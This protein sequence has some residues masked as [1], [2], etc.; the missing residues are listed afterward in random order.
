MQRPYSFL[1]YTFSLLLISALLGCIPEVGWSPDGRYLYFPAKGEIARWDSQTEQTQ[2]FP[3]PDATTVYQANVLFD[4]SILIQTNDKL[5]KCSSDGTSW[6]TLAEDADLFYQISNQ[7]HL[8]YTKTDQEKK[9]SQLFRDDETMPLWSAKEEFAY[10][11]VDASERQLLLATSHGLLL[12]DLQTRKAKMLS[13]PEKFCIPAAW[14]DE[15]TI[16]YLAMQKEDDAFG[17][18]MAYDLETHESRRVYR[19]VLWLLNSFR[20][21]GSQLAVTAFARDWRGKIKQDAPTRIVMLNLKTGKSSTVV[22]EPEG[23]VLPS[24]SPD[25]KQLAYIA[26]DKD[27]DFEQLKVL[28]LEKNRTIVLPEFNPP[29]TKWSKR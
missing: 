14:Q 20:L 12:I 6:Q 3:A 5:M 4:Q 29:E 2:T 21:Q 15:H 28:D 26:L 8:Y 7:G 11:R 22:R 17:D 10:P 18:L 23:A 19:G 25:G 1:G 24:L 16:L 9:T 27:E 13:L